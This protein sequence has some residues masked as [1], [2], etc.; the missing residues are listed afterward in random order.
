VQEPVTTM[1]GRGT[2]PAPAPLTPQSAAASLAAATLSAAG[3]RG[4]CA[5]L[6][7]PALFLMVLSLL[8]A[9]ASWGAHAT[10]AAAL[11][12]HQQQ[13]QQQQGSAVVQSSVPSPF[14]GKGPGTH[15]ASIPAQPC[16]HALHITT[17]KCVPWCC[18]GMPLPATEEEY[19]AVIS[20]PPHTHTHTHTLA[21]PPRLHR[22]GQC[23][24]GAVLCC[25]GCLL[26]RPAGPGRCRAAAGLHRHHGG[27]TW[28]RDGG[29]G[30]GPAAPGA[31]GA[32]A[33]QQ[34]QHWR[35]RHSCRCGGGLG[36]GG[37][38]GS[39]LPC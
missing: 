13:Q 24:G 29:G 3:A 7:C 32:A 11:R 8:A 30:A 1:G 25:P 17:F 31:A 12:R 9:G 39:R 27:G 10:Q 14:A 6:G 21:A 2:R 23:P 15:L 18:C 36:E 26:R 22:P 4:L 33:G 28:R 38:E 34:C 19:P 20:D 16:E 37:V 5:A 35:P